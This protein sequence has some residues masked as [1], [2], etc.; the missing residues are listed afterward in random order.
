VGF[1]RDH[2]PASR[3]QTLLQ[4]LTD[5]N[6][7]VE[8]LGKEVA[9]ERGIPLAFELAEETRAQIAANGERDGEI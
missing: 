7:V 2:D 9:V 3:R 1:T 5:I 4:R 6:T 8:L